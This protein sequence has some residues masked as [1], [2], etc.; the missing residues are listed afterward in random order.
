LITRSE[1]CTKPRTKEG[2]PQFEPP[3]P[4][5]S[6]AS[7]T[8]VWDLALLLATLGYVVFTLFGEWESPVLAMAVMLVSGYALVRPHIGKR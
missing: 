8:L 1:Y 2:G 5:K 4:S 3:E 7:K 6:R